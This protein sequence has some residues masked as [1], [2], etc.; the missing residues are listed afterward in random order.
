MC[1]LQFYSC[2]HLSEDSRGITKLA[3]SF[4]CSI[5]C[6][7]HEGES[8]QAVKAVTFFVT[9]SKFVCLVFVAVVGFCFCFFVVCERNC[10]PLGGG[11]LSKT[12]ICFIS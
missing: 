7:Q 5:R 12:P 11:E 3:C 9:K 4:P 10:F 8:K 1:I 6:V 2:H